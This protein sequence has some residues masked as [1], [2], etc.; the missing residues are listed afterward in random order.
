MNNVLKHWLIA[1][2][3]CLV[4]YSPVGSAQDVI[5]YEDELFTPA[6]L[7]S[8]LAPIALY[9]DS[10]LSHV[11]IAS[12]YPLEVIQAARWSRDNPGLEGE[13]AVA[14]AEDFD[15][16]PSIKAL[17]AFPE[18]L[19]RMDED[20]EWT[21]RIGDA[22]LTQEETVI[23]S[24]QGLRDRA[25][26]QGHL[27][28]DDHVRVVR[29][30]RVIYIE[31]A[32]PRYVYVPYYDPLVVYGRWWWD[33]YP[34]YRWRHPRYHAGISFYWGSGFHIA[35]TFYFSSFH[36]SRQRV[37]VVNHH[38]YP[39]RRFSSGREVASF[40]RAR[41][42]RH[43]P[44]HRRGVNY[45][46]P[47]GKSRFVERSTQ[48]SPRGSLRQRSVADQRRW[49]SDRRDQLNLQSSSRQRDRITGQRSRSGQLGDR[50]RR[51]GS[52]LP[53][54]VPSRSA[55]QATRQRNDRS[56]QRATR[57]AQVASA[58]RSTAR[59]TSG[60]TS[61]RL[62]SR[63]DREIASDRSSVR[64]SRPQ[65]RNR[66][67]DASAAGIRMPRSLEPEGTSQRRKSPTRRI[68][69][70][71]SQSGVQARQR[72]SSPPVRQQRV[73]PSREQRS[74]LPQR[75][76]SQPSRQPAQVRQAR[77]NTPRSARNHRARVQSRS[78]S[79]RERQRRN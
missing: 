71:P 46:H 50:S 1:L 16:D 59:P 79:T 31:P 19:A 6:E 20:I 8:I 25:Y 5:G 2:L 45:R 28:T 35:P 67:A 18:L 9:P 55:R 27:K 4:L 74:Q 58:R 33:A 52:S 41:H 65:V 63:A 38:H 73:R 62:R 51:A 48:A 14:T 60:D 72:A 54:A 11:L 64:S 66:E 37:V 39:A 40:H 77:Q 15:W 53:D 43:D 24:I 36:W 78:R 17:T 29:E 57:G 68:S 23:S 47:V 22:F 75:R 42:W 49:A 56:I 3:A 7:D 32:R 10:V 44:R 12:T 76:A 70:S 30:E 21:Q 13:F 26:A 61:Q 34:P 69:R